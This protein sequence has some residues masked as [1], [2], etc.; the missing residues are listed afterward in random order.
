MLKNI[1]PDYIVCFCFSPERRLA[2]LCVRLNIPYCYVLYDTYLKR[3]NSTPDCEMEEY[4]IRR[5]DKYLIPS[6]FYPEYKDYYQNEQIMPYDL[7][8]LLS[9]EQIV[10]ARMTESCGFPFLY[11]G[12][13][14]SFRNTKEVTDIFR[15]LG[16]VLDV[17]TGDS[18][19]ESDNLHRHQPLKGNELYAVIA[20]SEFLVAL[21]NNAPFDKYLPS[22]VY[23]YVSFAKP[24][25]V[26][27]NNEHSAIRE[28]LKDYPCWYY[29]M[30]GE[31]LD[32]L[33]SFVNEHRNWVC[34]NVESALF[35]QYLPQKSLNDI[36]QRILKNIR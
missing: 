25:I 19:T 29:Q 14:Q 35:G 4:V 33:V 7:P 36:Y 12:Q 26:F 9:D 18:I 5:S 3:P 1:K 28:F 24:I 31:P 13:L 34:N 16:Y 32:D 27:G 30:I 2:D 22:K 17:Y 15:M 8:L 10:R 11:L 20:H 23:L 21:D 6:F